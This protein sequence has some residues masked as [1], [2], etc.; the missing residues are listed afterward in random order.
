M[1]QIILILFGFLFLSLFK[2]KIQTVYVAKEPLN[3][4][5]IYSY[6]E[7]FPEI[8]RNATTYIPYEKLHTSKDGSHLTMAGG[9][10]INPNNCFKKYIAISRDLKWLYPFGTIVEIS[11]VGEFSG[12]YEVQD[13]K[14]EGYTHQIDILVPTKMYKRQS[15]K[16]KI[17]ILRKGSGKYFKA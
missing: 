12:I 6:K 16:C 14:G 8:T 11:D 17:K 2:N 4:L 3:E 13:L 1:K 10:R 9:K 7:E 15:Y 5:V